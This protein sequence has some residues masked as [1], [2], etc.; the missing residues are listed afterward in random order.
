MIADNE[1][2]TTFTV[3]RFFHE[4]HARPTKVPLLDTLNKFCVDPVVLVS[5]RYIV[6]NYGYILSTIYTF[7]II[8][9]HYPFSRGLFTNLTQIRT[10]I[11]ITSIAFIRCN[12]TAVS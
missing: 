6:L 7:V 5:C 2:F 10:W 3:T 9:P 11:S 8:M 4:C 12:Y 1:C